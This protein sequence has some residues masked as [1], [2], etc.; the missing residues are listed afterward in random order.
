MVHPNN[1]HFIR[2]IFHCHYS[3]VYATQRYTC[4]WCST[5][6]YLWIHT[7]ANMSDFA[8][9]RLNWFSVTF[10]RM[11]SSTILYSCAP[12]YLNEPRLTFSFRFGISRSCLVTALVVL[13]S[14]SC[15]TRLNWLQILAG[16]K[17][18]RLLYTC[19]I[20]CIC[21]LSDTRFMFIRWWI[22]FVD[23]RHSVCSTTFK[24]QFCMRCRMA[25]SR[26]PC[27]SM[28]PGWMGWWL[29]PTLHLCTAYV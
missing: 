12:R 18:F 5:A 11:S 29:V 13:L 14:A 19:V 24:A 26:A 23:V 3:V 22:S 4:L 20:V 9:V 15:P 1:H 8:I 28:Q 10:P 6:L 7:N 16:A 25:L 2:H 27:V 17:S 21:L